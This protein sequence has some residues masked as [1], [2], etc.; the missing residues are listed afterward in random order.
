VADVPA[1]TGRTDGMGFLDDLKD[2]AEEFGERAKEGLGAAR[3][4]A[5]DLIGDVRDRLDQDETSADEDV[6][7][8]DQ[9]TEAV[10]DEP[11]GLDEAV[12]EAGAATET[13]ADAVGDVGPAPVADPLEPG[14]RV[15]DAVDA[16]ADSTSGEI[17]EDPL[18]PRLEAVDPIVEP[19]GTTNPGE[20]PLEAS[21]DRTV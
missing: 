10:N 11:R 18:D 4:K 6:A 7:T 19:A 14:D 1:Q 3:D 16:P 17:T 8:A 9:P 2:K 21:P 13:A 20:D 15:A 5:S 12:A